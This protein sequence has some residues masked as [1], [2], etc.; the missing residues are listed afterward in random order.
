MPQYK[1]FMYHICARLLAQLFFKGLIIS[2]SCSYGNNHIK[3]LL[4][5]WSEFAND[6]LPA[7]TVETHLTVPLVKVMF[8]KRNSLHKEF[9]LHKQ[10][11]HQECFSGVFFFHPSPSLQALDSIHRSERTMQKLILKDQNTCA[12]GR[13]TFRFSSTTKRIRA[14]LLSS[15]CDCGQIGVG[16]VG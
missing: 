16:W 2:P 14:T 6:Y 10:H 13:S 11:K 4:H 5:L 7:T 8:G 3:R 1:Y 9:S 15:N 12:A